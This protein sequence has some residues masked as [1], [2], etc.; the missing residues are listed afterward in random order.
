MNGHPGGIAHTRHL[1]DLASLPA[2]A[3]ILDLGAGAGESV[4]LMRELGYDASGLDLSPRAEFVQQGD[5]LQTGLP[6]AAVD[7][8]RSQ[9]SFFVSGNVQQALQEAHRLL[10]PG[11]KLLL[12][13]VFF[14]PA[15]ALMQN[16]G[17]T[18]LCKEDL[19]AQWREYYLDAL[20]HDDAP[21]RISFPR[22]KCSY[23]LLIGRKDDHGSV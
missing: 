16:A 7:A 5:L 6:D 15:E 2:G 4:L 18:V 13:D 10:K 17:L 19:T 1:L 8:V 14:S 23:L 11:G 21:C 22:G 20:W 12:S 9:C 3:R